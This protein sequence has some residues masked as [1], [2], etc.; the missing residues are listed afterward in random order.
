MA[1]TPIGT[2][3]ASATGSPSRQTEQRQATEEDVARF[4]EASSQLDEKP[5]QA[6][7]G[8]RGPEEDQ[9]SNDPSSL[10][11]RR[12]AP[13]RNKDDRDKGGD[14]Q[15][16]NGGSIATSTPFQLPADQIVEAS[17]PSATI[18]TIAT[19]IVT[20][21][22]VGPGGPTGQEE[23]RIQL[24]DDVLDGSQIRLVNTGKTL[25][26]TFVSPTKSSE[27]YLLSRQAELATTLGERLGRDVRVQVIQNAAEEQAL[28]QGNA[29][30]GN[31]DPGQQNQ[32]RSRNW[33]MYN[34][35]EDA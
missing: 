8:G 22:Q 28:S 17:S 3:N 29:N 20:A 10:F 31:A 35:D 9:R 25:E 24:N 14:R 7:D 27:A 13:D 16:P 23:V 4:R 12:E 1:T 19:E 15:P 32:G 34:K 5:T 26:V 2:Q 6:E 11:R 21:I 30:N 18:A 33:H